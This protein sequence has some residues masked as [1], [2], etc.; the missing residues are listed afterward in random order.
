MF[1]SPR[2]REAA[3]AA[4]PAFEAGEITLDLAEGSDARGPHLVRD[5]RIFLL[6]CSLRAFGAAERKTAHVKPNPSTI[7]HSGAASVDRDITQIQS[8]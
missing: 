6:S 3:K 7:S 8:S 2:Q 5:L 1:K 4:N